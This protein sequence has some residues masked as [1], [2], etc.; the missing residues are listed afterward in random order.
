MHTNINLIFNKLVYTEAYLIHIKEDILLGTYYYIVFE[1][2]IY[3]KIKF[4]FI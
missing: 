1:I 4:C 3:I 2:N